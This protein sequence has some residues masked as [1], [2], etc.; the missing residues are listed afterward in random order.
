MEG[1]RLGQVQAV[2]RERGQLLV[3]ARVG[4]GQPHAVRR[5]LA[6]ALAEH[7]FTYT[8]NTY[9]HTPMHSFHKADTNNTPKEKNRAQ[10]AV[11]TLVHIGVKL[12]RGVGATAL[13]PDPVLA[14]QRLVLAQ[15]HVHVG[16]E[17]T[18]GRLATRLLAI[19]ERAG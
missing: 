7:L 3:V 8:L 14:R 6:H 2:A 9:I 16:V 1:T 17:N 18:V 11:E 13:V 5:T 15:T 4:V 19:D 10:T 12:A